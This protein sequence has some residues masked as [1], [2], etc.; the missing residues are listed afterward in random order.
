MI[1]VPLEVGFFFDSNRRHETPDYSRSLP[2][3]PHLPRFGPSDKKALVES[4]VSLF[5]A[6][7]MD[8]W[9]MDAVKDIKYA[10]WVGCMLV[11]S[12]TKTNA[13]I[14]KARRDLMKASMDY[15]VTMKKESTAA[16]APDRGA[17]S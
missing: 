9:R 14:T 8:Q 3:R 11:I 7:I 6:S 17:D 10:I 15:I 13:A 4:I 2:A 16:S 1:C 12:A 5:K